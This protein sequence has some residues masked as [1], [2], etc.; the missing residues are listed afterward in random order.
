[1]LSLSRL[2]HALYGTA[3]AQRN[4]E[5]PQQSRLSRQERLT[6]LWASPR[7]AG[8]QFHCRV[9]VDEEAGDPDFISG[10]RWLQPLVGDPWASVSHQFQP[11]EKHIQILLGEEAPHQGF[12]SPG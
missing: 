1:M 2:P 6:T 5:W 11:T 7:T 8:N 10:E 9:G 12:L 3:N 4:C